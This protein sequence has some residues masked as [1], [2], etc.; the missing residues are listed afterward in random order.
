VSLRPR[1]STGRVAFDAEEPVRV[2]AQHSVAEN[3]DLVEGIADDQALGGK[4]RI[5][6]VERG[7]AFLEVMQI[8]PTALRA[9]DAADHGG[10]APVGVLYAGRKTFAAAGLR[11]SPSLATHSRS[12]LTD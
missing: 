4:G 5:E 10:S 11:C 7:L 9:V 1:R 12:P 8:N 2:E 6:P 3:A